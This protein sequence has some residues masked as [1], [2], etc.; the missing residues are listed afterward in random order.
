MT[1]KE[2]RKG[3]RQRAAHLFQAFR[4]NYHKHLGFNTI[5]YGERGWILFH[6]DTYDT[7]AMPAGLYKGWYQHNAVKRING[8]NGQLP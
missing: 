5:P 2:Q 6:A 8:P 7:L 4:R 1:R 3:Y